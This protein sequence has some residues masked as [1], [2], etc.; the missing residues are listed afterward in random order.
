M[1]GALIGMLFADPA[2]VAETGLLGF[3]Q[4][5]DSWARA[6]IG[7]MIRY[8]TCRAAMTTPKGRAAAKKVW[9]TRR[10]LNA[11]A[12]AHAAEAAAKVA[13]KDYYEQRG[14]RVAFF[15]GKTGAPRTGIIDAVAF[16][17]GRKN[18]DVLDLRLVQL[19]GGKAGITA[20]EIGRLLFQQPVRPRVAGPERPVSTFRTQ[21][22]F[23]LGAYRNGP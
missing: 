11:W 9:K 13:F 18:A 15:E 5:A 7:R 14:W 3:R 2:F 6:S 10:T 8:R 12:R 1:R 22:S 4:M 16:R 17:L 19:K 23:G 21:V 20:A